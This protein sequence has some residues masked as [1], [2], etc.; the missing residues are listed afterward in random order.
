MINHAYLDDFL[1]NIYQTTMY[2][3]DECIELGF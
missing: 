3:L 1:F 2:F